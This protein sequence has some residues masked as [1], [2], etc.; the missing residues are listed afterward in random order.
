MIEMVFLLEEASAKVFLES[1]LP[2]LLH[3]DIHFR[4]IPFHGKQDLQKQLTNKIRGYLNPNARFIVIQDQD[5]FPDCLVL[6]E[7]L[8]GLCQKSGRYPHCL[9]RIAC[10]ELEAFYLADLKA[11]EQ[12]LGI[13]GI[14]KKQLTKKY[15]TPDR[16]SNPSSELKSLTAD[17]YEKVLSSRE[18]GRHIDLDNTRSPSFRNLISGIR[19]VQSELLS[20]AQQP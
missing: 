6:K 4:L 8:L 13:D 9:V 10:K 19:R 2:R 11:V 7:R 15:R 18:I 1:L 14:V 5:R 20:T 3:Q 16:L 12:S 17:K